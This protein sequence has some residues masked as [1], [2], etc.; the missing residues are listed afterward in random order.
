MLAPAPC[1]AD[2]E[3]AGEISNGAPREIAPGSRKPVCSF[4]A[5]AEDAA[6]A[7]VSTPMARAQ[8]TILLSFPQST[9]ALPG[10]CP[11]GPLP[12]PHTIVGEAQAHNRCRIKNR[13]RLAA[14]NRAAAAPGVGEGDSARLLQG[15]PVRM[16]AAGHS[17]PVDV[18]AIGRAPLRGENPV[19]VRGERPHA[20]PFA[21]DLT[22]DDDLMR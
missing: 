11:F 17:R 21:V 19:P 1:T 20:S 10:P 2:M 12:S 16:R 6:K 18:F 4:P 14:A 9:V 3:T 13:L 15:E 5:E 22:L 7:S 8:R